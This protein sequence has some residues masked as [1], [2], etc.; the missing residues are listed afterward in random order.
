MYGMVMLEVYV[1]RADACSYDV[2]SFDGRLV[3]VVGSVY[4]AKQ[5]VPLLVS[6]LLRTV[7]SLLEDPK[8]VSILPM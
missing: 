1:S 7:R 5:G 3:G 6:Y 2:S 8:L 4:L